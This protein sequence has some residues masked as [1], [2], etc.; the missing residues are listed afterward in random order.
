MNNCKYIVQYNE[1]IQDQH[2]KILKIMD[3]SFSA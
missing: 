1:L 2:G 3:D